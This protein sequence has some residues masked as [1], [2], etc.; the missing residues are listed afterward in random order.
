M[1]NPAAAASVKKYLK[2]FQEEQGRAHIVFRQAK[3]IFIPKVWPIASFIQRKL[4][5]KGI[6]TKEKYVLL[7]DQAYLKRI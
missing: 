6:S 5:G 7:R 2:S 3:P 1:G 4:E